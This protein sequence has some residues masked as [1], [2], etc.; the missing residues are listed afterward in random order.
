MGTRV[1]IGGLPR[2]ATSREVQ[3]GFSRYG[4]IANIWIA[5]NPPGFAFVDFEDPRD[6]DDAIR[7]MDGRDFLGG[8]IRVELAKGGS[9]RDRRDD[10]RRGGGGRGGDRFERGGRN[11]PQRTEFRV[12]ITDLP[13]GVDWRDVKDHLRTAGEVTFCNVENDGTAIAEFQSRD[14]VQ[15]AIEKLDDKEF[16][17]SYIRITA[18]SSEERS[19]SRSPRRDRSPDRR[20]RSRS[21]ERRESPRRSRSPSPGGRSPPP[22]KNS[23]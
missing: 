18:A 6:A 14:D 22:R 10:D 13:R 21:P 8:R 15:N 11:P 12:R 17:G 1:Y 3:D 9:R 20:S 2:D 23:V 19:R 4:H 16:R 5:R 7:S